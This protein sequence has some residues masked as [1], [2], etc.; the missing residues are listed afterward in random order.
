MMLLICVPFA[1]ALLMVAIRNSKARAVTMYICAAGVAAMAIATAVM[2][3]KA[4]MQPVEFN[5]PG[6]AIFDKIILVGDFV[7]MAFVIFQT[8]KNKKVWI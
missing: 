6:S 5:L 4:G 8:F 3:L 2:W 7:L 1:M